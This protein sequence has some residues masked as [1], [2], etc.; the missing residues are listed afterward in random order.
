MRFIY[1]SYSSA[2]PKRRIGYN[3][4]KDWLLSKQT[5][6]HLLGGKT[7]HGEV[8]VVK[9]KTRNGEFKRVILRYCKFSV[10][11]KTH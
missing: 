11:E 5:F 7:F 9:A 2:A 6:F 8:R 1:A 3:K 4:I 10:K